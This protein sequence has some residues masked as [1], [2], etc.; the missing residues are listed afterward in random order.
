MKLKTGDYIAL[1]CVS[2]ETLKKVLDKFAIQFNEYHPISAREDDNLFYGV[3]SEHDICFLNSVYE[4]GDSRRL[5]TV[6]QVL[7][8][9][10]VMPKQDRYKD[11]DGKSDYLD[12]TMKTMTPEQFRGAMMWTIGKYIDRL[13]EKDPVC[14][15]VY[16]IA[17]YSQRWLEYE[18]KLLDD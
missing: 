16:K 11:K 10:S 17:D 8:T 5:L 2:D 12:R 3:D 4:F 14:E 1:G 18:K 7:G 13:G 15:E 9:E 6:E